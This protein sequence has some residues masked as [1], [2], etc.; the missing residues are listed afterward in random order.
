MVLM[1]NLALISVIVPIVSFVILTSYS[2][3]CYFGKKTPKHI[4]SAVMGAGSMGISSL[5]AIITAILF[6]ID[7]SHTEEKNF[8][9]LKFGVNDAGKAPYTFIVEIGVLLDG[10]S[11][12]GFALI[13]TIA[14]I[15]HFYAV[16]YMKEDEGHVRFFATM[17]LFSA[18][19]L[20][21]VLSPN[22]L[23]AF[24]F[25]EM[26][27]ITSYFLIGF[28]WK[29]KHNAFCGRKAFMYNRIG[30]VMFMAGFILLYQEFSTFSFTE[31]SNADFGQMSESKMAI[32]GLL[33][34]GG[35]IGKSA[36]FPLSN[37]LPD[38]MSGP[39]PVSALLHSSTMVK[40]GIFLVARTFWIYFKVDS[41]NHV[42]DL[43]P[44]AAISGATIVAVVAGFTALYA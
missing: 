42:A 41:H 3:W 44:G 36:Q 9:W 15:I 29:D 23:Q 4:V 30:D 6:F 18:S 21:F 26:L 28:W 13:S 31:L 12:I 39:T 17:N 22:F 43:S 27:G 40:A 16:E 10:L 33:I 32:I 38:A 14:F 8:T 35:A 20:F 11:V 1:I 19:M 7:G 25:W 2:A 24:V 5:L 34:F 37:W